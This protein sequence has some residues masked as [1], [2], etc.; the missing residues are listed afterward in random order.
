MLSRKQ[1]VDD[2][3]ELT[4]ETMVGLVGHWL[5]MYNEDAVIGNIVKLFGHAKEF[6]KE[7]TEETTNRKAKFKEDIASEL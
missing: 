6:F 7:I 5:Q 4:E 2:I 1:T 3:R